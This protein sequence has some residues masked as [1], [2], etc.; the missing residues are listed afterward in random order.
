MNQYLLLNVAIGGFAAPI[1]PNF[2]ESAMVI[3]YVRVY[4]SEAILSTETIKNSDLKIQLYPNPVNEQLFIKS[5]ETIATNVEI[6]NAIGKRVLKQKY[7][8]NNVKLNLN[9]F[10]KGVYFV[11]IATEATTISR[12]VIVE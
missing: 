3:D 8:S 12:K 6:Y 11:K 9:G 7:S 1:D 4:K 5:F 2:T 10:V